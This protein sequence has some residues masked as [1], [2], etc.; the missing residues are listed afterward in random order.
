[1][2]LIILVV[3]IV[4]LYHYT[5]R[6]PKQKKIRL[7]HENQEYAQKLQASSTQI[8]LKDLSGLARACQRI[9]KAGLC[10][11]SPLV[12]QITKTDDLFAHLNMTFTIY[13]IPTLP[14]HDL[15]YES[16]IMI[17][18]EEAKFVQIPVAYFKAVEEAKQNILQQPSAFGEATEKIR[19]LLEKSCYQA[20]Y[21]R[22]FGENQNY[23]PYNIDGYKVN[24]SRYPSGDVTVSCDWN[25]LEVGKYQT[26]RKLF[27]Y[28][29]SNIK[30]QFPDATAVMSGQSI[31]VAF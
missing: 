3:V 31:Q 10:K 22:I 5:I 19:N 24:V 28:L 17:G 20:I 30:K 9:A 23:F 16:A 27:S 7:E 15:E 1:M 11:T 13:E 29:H 2:E 26:D 14:F 21:Q 18:S 25:F 4:I 6:K 12:V 8:A